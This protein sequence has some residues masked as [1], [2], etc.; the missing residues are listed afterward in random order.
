MTLTEVIDVEAEAIETGAK[1]VKNITN[2]LDMGKRN[3]FQRRVVVYL[4]L[5]ISCT[6]PGDI[7]TGKQEENTAIKKREKKP[8]NA[9]F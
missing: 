9:L 4:I 7:A 6:N 2:F 8:T 1:Y 5:L 3:Y